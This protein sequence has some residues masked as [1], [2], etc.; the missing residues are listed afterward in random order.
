MGKKKVQKFVGRVAKHFDKYFTVYVYSDP[1]AA[2]SVLMGPKYI[3]ITANSDLRP[4]EAGGLI[5][6]L[7][8]LDLRCV[9]CGRRYYNYFRVE[10]QNGSVVRAICGYCD[11]TI[12]FAVAYF[13]AIDPLIVSTPFNG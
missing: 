13:D 6:K 11:P 4:E 8:D 3:I 10:M 1:D 7:F 2:E 9:R 12:R 5:D